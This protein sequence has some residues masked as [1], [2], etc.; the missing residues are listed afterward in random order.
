MVFLVQAK[1]LLETTKKQ[2]VSI[3]IR[4]PLAST[5]EHQYNDNNNV[6]SIETLEAGQMI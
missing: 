4:G 3:E 5:K 6:F 2:Q 1:L